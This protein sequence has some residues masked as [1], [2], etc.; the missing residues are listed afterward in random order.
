MTG[1]IKELFEL[2]VKYNKLTNQ[3]MIKILE[4]VEQKK[5][6]ENMGSYYG[7]I[8]GILNHHLLADIGWLRVLGTHISSLD[9]I[10]SLLERFPSGRPLPNQ[11]YWATLDE[12]KSD[13]AEIDDLIERVIKSIPAN[14]YKNILKIE[15]RRG[16]F[17]Y[18]TWRILLHLFN[19]QTHHRG[20]VAVLLDQ[21]K[22]ENDYSNLLWKV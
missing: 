1:D 8:L 13:R 10:S 5:L 19:H 11:L 16:T 6:T 21:L 18:T 17:E 7:S 14:Q 9:F 4:G 20:G 3:D 2:L 15:G 12:Y 22:I